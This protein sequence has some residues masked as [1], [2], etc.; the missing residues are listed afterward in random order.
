MWEVKRFSLV[1]FVDFNK[2]TCWVNPHYVTGLSVGRD[3]NTTIINLVDGNV[4]VAH[5]MDEVLK[6]LCP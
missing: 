3:E 5:T 4:T 1:S 6:R 2:Q